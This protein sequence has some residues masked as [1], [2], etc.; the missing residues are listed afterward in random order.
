MRRTRIGRGGRQGRACAYCKQC[1]ACLS[2][3]SFA[4]PSWIYFT[5]YIGKFQ[6]WPCDLAIIFRFSL[7]ISS[8]RSTMLCSFP[9]LCGRGLYQELA[10]LHLFPSSMSS[11]SLYFC[12]FT[13]FVFLVVSLGCSAARDGELILW[14]NRQIYLRSLRFLEL[15]LEF[16]SGPH[17]HTRLCITT[18]ACLLQLLDPVQPLC[19]LFPS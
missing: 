8:I 12:Q 9:F 3:Q 16:V 14:F 6:P 19:L 13:R 5:F 4:H 11:T 1:M 7:E 15:E 2:C 17:D 10:I 18:F